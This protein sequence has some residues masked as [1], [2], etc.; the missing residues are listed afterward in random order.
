MPS[1]KQIL[2]AGGCGALSTTIVATKCA[3]Y[4]LT[5]TT[6]LVKQLFGGA[7]KMTNEFAPSPSMGVGPYL[8]NA[9]EKVASKGFDLL[10][11]AQKKMR[12]ALR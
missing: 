6:G 9:T 4:G 7:Q 2:K 5:F 12:E 11:A 3:K 8:L 10:I 1:T